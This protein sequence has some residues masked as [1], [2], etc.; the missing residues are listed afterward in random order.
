MSRIMPH[1]LQRKRALGKFQCR[2]KCTSKGKDG[3]I[4]QHM[5]WASN[6]FMFQLSLF[7]PHVCKVIAIPA[8]LQDL[9]TPH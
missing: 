7:G 4:V 8:H 1:H 6:G 9:R 3:I 5:V 2:W